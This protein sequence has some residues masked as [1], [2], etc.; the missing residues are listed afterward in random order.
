MTKYL[1]VSEDTMDNGHKCLNYIK[2]TN[3]TIKEYFKFSGSKNLVC[4]G[5]HY[6]W[7]LYLNNYEELKDTLLSHYQLI[8]KD[9]ILEY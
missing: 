6:L 3:K 8:S 9:Y 2:I 1:Y 7:G 4:V 5:D